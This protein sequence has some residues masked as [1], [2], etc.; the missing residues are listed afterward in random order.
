[1]DLKNIFILKHS[2]PLIVLG[3][4]MLLSLDLK[5]RQHASGKTEQGISFFACCLVSILVFNLHYC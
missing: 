1:M 5:Y 2:G 3:R 4:Q